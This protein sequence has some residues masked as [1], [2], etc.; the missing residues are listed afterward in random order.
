M[1]GSSMKGSDLVD[2]RKANRMKKRPKV[3]IIQRVL[4]QYRVPF[5]EGLKVALDSH[6]VEL[7]LIHGVGNLKDKKKEFLGR[8]QWAQ[9]VPEKYLNMGDFFLVFQPYLKLL[10]DADLI[11][12]QQELRWLLN[13]ILLLKRQLGLCRLAFWGHGLNR[14]ADPQS[15]GNFIK[16]KLSSKVDW[17]FAYTQGVADT[18]KRIGFPPERITVVQ[19]SIDTSGLLSIKQAISP[20]D[21]EQVRRRYNILSS[22]RV[23]LFCGAMYKHKRLE[24]LLQACR[25]IKQDMPDFTMIFIG[26]G[27][28]QHLVQAACDKNPWMRFAGPLLGKDKVA[29]YMLAD[30]VLMPGLVG[31]TVLDSFCLGVP[32]ITTDY[33]FHS[34]EIEYLENGMNGIITANSLEEYSQAVISVL[35]DSDKRE[36]LRQGC[37]ESA[38]R[39]SL[40]QMVENFKEGI[41]Q[42]LAKM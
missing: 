41:I 38:A 33:R 4:S 25:R 26:A 8:L 24:F 28:D 10:K 11:I 20:A 27:P 35:H 42:C 17:W 23:G 19:N 34:P 9:E 6:Q 37:R 22:S 36:R 14:Q 2:R 15:P 5:F 12:V 30:V 18:V 29:L 31:L 21:I 1:R 7:D 39:Y 3:I 16:Q 13:Y 32:L 40:G